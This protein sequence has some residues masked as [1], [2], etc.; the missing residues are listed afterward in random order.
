MAEQ[1]LTELSPSSV[2]YHLPLVDPTRTRALAQGSSSALRPRLPA[3]APCLAGYTR[4]PGRACS[5]HDLLASS[6]SQRLLDLP[7]QH[8]T[9]VR[10]A[11]PAPA[12][13][14][15]RPSPRA[16]RLQ[17]LKTPWQPR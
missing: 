12:L 13:R 2:P 7:P 15:L 5:M 6:D 14:P 3:T 4:L 9:T 10:L 11:P 1:T 16:A 8:Q 17:R